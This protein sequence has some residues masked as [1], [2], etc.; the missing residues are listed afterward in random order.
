MKS[1]SIEEVKDRLYKLHGNDIII[2]EKTYISARKK[3][4]FIDKDYGEWWREPQYVIGSS[5]KNTSRERGYEKLS[6]IHR[7]KKDEVKKRIYNVH[8]DSVA[9]NYETYKN[10]F[11]KSEFIDKDYGSFWSRPRDV[12]RGHGHPKRGIENKKKTWF[13]KYGVD[14]P[15]K[16]LDVSLKQAKSLNKKYILNHWKDGSQ[17]ICRGSYEY[18]VVLNFNFQKEYYEKDIR[19]IMPSGK[20]YFVD[21]YLPEKD[22][23]IE[24][25]GFFRKDAKEKWDWFHE[26]HPNSEL[27]DKKKLKEMNIL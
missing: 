25:K 8:G 16:C 10:S 7:L 4:K 14:N 18:K 26:T 2:D 17:V 6:E 23:Y 19:F 20:V 1:L 12:F 3:A 21:F 11:E 5:A 22:L 15:S 24:V 9:I 27:W 13:I